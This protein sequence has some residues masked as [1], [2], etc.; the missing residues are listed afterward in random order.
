MSLVAKGSV[1]AIDNGAGTAAPAYG[2]ATTA[3]DYAVCLLYSNSSATTDP[4][5]CIDAT[6]KKLLTAGSAYGWT[7]LWYKT[8]LGASESAPTWDIAGGPSVGWAQLR[9][10]AGTASTAPDSSGSGSGDPCVATAAASDGGSTDDIIIGAGFGGSNGVSYTSALTDSSGASLTVADLDT[11]ANGTNTEGYWFAD[12]VAKATGADKDS[13]TLSPSAYTGTTAIIASF[14]TPSG[15]SSLSETAAFAVSAS[16]SGVHSLVLSRA[17][18]FV[19]LARLVGSQSLTT[20]RTVAVAVSGG[21]AATPVFRLAQSAALAV[22][23]RLVPSVSL[24]LA[25]SATLAAASR[26]RAVYGSTLNKSAWLVSSARLV[27]VSPGLVTSGVAR[28]G[29]AGRLAAVRA[30]TLARSAVLTVTGRL[31]ASYAV[32]T[33]PGTVALVDAPLAAVKFADVSAAT[34]VLDDVTLSTVTLADSV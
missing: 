12:A 33:S 7:S 31:S 9:E 2:A 22:S 26:L 20:L 27:A 24:A 10:Y 18:G 3:G 8:N 32:R 17:A 4:Y 14:K 6:W 25:R 16:L 28:T 29:A 21:L 5:T 13:A 34:V 15:G 11:S 19:A 30:L 1:A 23:G